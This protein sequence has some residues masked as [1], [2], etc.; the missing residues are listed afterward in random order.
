MSNPNFNL[1]DYKTSQVG[2]IKEQ[3]EDEG[4]KYFVE[5]RGDMMTGALSLPNL[6]IYNNGSISF[7]DG[8]HQ[9]TA[10]TYSPSLLTTENIFNEN[11]SFKKQVKLYDN[12]NSN[13]NYNSQIY[14]YGKILQFTNINASNDGIISF[15]TSAT[16]S[17]I[18]SSGNE[19]S[20]INSL[21]CNTINL[22]GSDLENYINTRINNAVQSVIS[23]VP[24]GTI[25]SSLQNSLTGYLKLDGSTYNISGYMGLAVLA[26]D[27][28]WKIETNQ[29]NVN[30]YYDWEFKLPDLRGCFLRMS[31]TNSNSIYS[32]N[33]GSTIG[34]FQKDGIKSHTHNFTRDLETE[35]VAKNPVGS[36]GVK[37]RDDKPSTLS[38]SY[39]IKDRNGLNLEEVD[40]TRPF[41][42]SVNYFIKY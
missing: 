2:D 30:A 39:A 15:K 14:Q 23:N 21:S 37:I 1:N 28:G 34:S 38:T 32:N 42:F 40:E 31:G 10:Y 24:I 7:S 4:E 35:I 25:I 22:N 19:I 27:L 26:T 33:I 29:I 13:S 41:N 5:L 8:T 20:G 16:G 18:I 17:V 3:I 11:N 12:L 36:T 6:S 9:T